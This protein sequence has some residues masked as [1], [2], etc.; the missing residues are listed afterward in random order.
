MSQTEI[1]K[2]KKK[3]Q[4]TGIFNTKER[5]S[6]AERKRGSLWFSLAGPRGGDAELR[7]GLALQSSPHKERDLVLPR[8]RKGANGSPGVQ[9]GKQLPRRGTLALGRACYRSERGKEQRTSGGVGR[10]PVPRCLSNTAGSVLD[11]GGEK[12]CWK[13]R[14]VWA[15]CLTSPIL[16]SS[17]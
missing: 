16:S 7:K 5:N 13:R 12:K 9:A 8:A 2:K 3:K 17:A 11:C 6:E 4:L 10:R 15:R 14:R 1:T